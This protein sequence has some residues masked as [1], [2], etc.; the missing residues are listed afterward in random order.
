MPL[1]ERTVMHV[2]HYSLLQRALHW[3][4]A[5]LVL[6]NIFLGIILWVYGFDG[7]NESFGSEI[8]NNIYKYH[9]T[10]GVIILI[11]M[12]FRLA[13]RTVRGVPPPERGMTQ[14]ELVLSAW[15]HR[16]LYATLIL[17]PVV[18]W[19]ATATGGFPIEF[20]NMN[21]PALVS[22]NPE[23]SVT[24][25]RVHGLLG[26]FILGLIGLHIAGALRHWLVKRDGVMRRMSLMS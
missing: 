20:F 25:Y 12:I 21:L 3:M 17:E 22:K 16:L 5:I 14:L 6:V 18:G 26:L 15:V 9:K 7:L 19:L 23:L 10:N 13:F 2:T 24:L 4:V 11:L 1:E 8:T